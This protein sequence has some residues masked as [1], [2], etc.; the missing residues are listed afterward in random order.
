MKVA[1]YT[2]GL[3]EKAPIGGHTGFCTNHH[4]GEEGDFEVVGEDESP[5]VKLS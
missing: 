2:A 4:H 1:V 5:V 3:H